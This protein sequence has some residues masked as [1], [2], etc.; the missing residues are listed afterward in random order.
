MQK[1][2]ALE[3]FALIKYP[4]DDMPDLVRSAIGKLLSNYQQQRELERMREDASEGPT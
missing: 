2:S 1:L 3:I 4:L